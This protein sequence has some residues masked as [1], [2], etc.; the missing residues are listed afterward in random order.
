MRPV[1]GLVT[2]SCVNLPVDAVLRSSVSAY[3]ASLG[4]QPL[5][6]QANGHAGACDSDALAERRFLSVIVKPIG[7]VCKVV[8]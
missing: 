6:G 3:R 2:L 4:G 5:N 7:R 1:E 8:K